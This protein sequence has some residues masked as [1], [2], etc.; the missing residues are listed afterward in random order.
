MERFETSL[1]CSFGSADPS[2]ELKSI[3]V[4][5]LRLISAGEKRVGRL[6]S[7]DDMS[8]EGCYGHGRIVFES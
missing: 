5:D 2:L 8:E 4:H 6:D 7:R 3:S 1:H